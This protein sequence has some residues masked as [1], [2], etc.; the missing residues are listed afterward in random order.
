MMKLLLCLLCDDLVT[1]RSAHARQCE[2]GESSGQYLSEG[3]AKYSGP[4]LLVGFGNSTFADV[5]R[6]QLKKSDK[7]LDK[8]GGFGPY[9]DELKGRCFD[10]FIIPESASTSMR[11]G[12]IPTLEKILEMRAA[13]RASLGQ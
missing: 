7:D 5:I 3:L 12:E 13:R 6:Q 1:L 9:R 10:A 11:D 4:A 2:C 8:M